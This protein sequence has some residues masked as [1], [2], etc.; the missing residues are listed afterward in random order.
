MQFRFGALTALCLAAVAT[1]CDSAT[2]TA[3][4]E[5]GV[6]QHSAHA[7]NVISAPAS[8]RAGTDFQGTILPYGNGC[9][10]AAGTG[11]RYY[12]STAVI[13]PYDNN[14]SRL[15][16]VFGC[17]DILVRPRHTVTLRFPSAG[18]ARIR[19]EGLREPRRALVTIEHTVSISE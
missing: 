10:S 6:I 13:R 2:D 7:G 12:G 19:V 4:D 8:A 5:L 15:S 14:A 16:G 3:P 17:D 9:V 11:V 1:S 18:T